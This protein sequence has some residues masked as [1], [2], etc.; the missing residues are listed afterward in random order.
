MNRRAL[1]WTWGLLVLVL[2]GCQSLQ[3]DA[4]VTRD[5]WEPKTETASK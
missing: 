2:G 1:G 4:D 5:Q 3:Q